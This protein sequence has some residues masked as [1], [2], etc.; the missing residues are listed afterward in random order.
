VITSVHSDM[1]SRKTSCGK[2]FIQIDKKRNRQTERQIAYFL[3][4]RV[5]RVATE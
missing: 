1:W 3:S 4:L 5:Y 2:T